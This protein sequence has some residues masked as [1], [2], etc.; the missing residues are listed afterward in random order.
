MGSIGL[1]Y[2][3]K[4]CQEGLQLI[5]IQF[6]VLALGDLCKLHIHFHGCDMYYENI[7]TEFILGSGFVDVAEANDMVMLFPQVINSKA[8][9]RVM[10]EDYFQL[11]DYSEEVLTDCWNTNGHLDDFESFK[12]ASKEGVQMAGVFNMIRDLAGL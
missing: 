5:I 10:H 2:L 8:T 4:V 11:T 12:F 6:Q 7:G 1:V 9:R 3:P